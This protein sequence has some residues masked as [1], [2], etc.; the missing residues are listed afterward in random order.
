M[1]SEKSH[2]KYSNNFRHIK[3]VKPLLATRRYVFLQLTEDEDKEKKGDELGV[4]RKGVVGNERITRVIIKQL[5][6]QRSCK[7]AHLA[8]NIYWKIIGRESINYNFKDDVVL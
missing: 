7:L 2:K 5:W 6:L 4:W 8:P 1:S 3:I